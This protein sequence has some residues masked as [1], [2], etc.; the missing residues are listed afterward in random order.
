MH[1]FS[2]ITKQMPRVSTRTPEEQKE[3]RRQYMNNYRKEW[4]KSHNPHIVCPDCGATVRRFSVRYHV[5]TVKHLYHVNPVVRG[6][7]EEIDRE[8]GHIPIKIHK[9]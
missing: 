5:K 7:M 3:Q 6:A 9:H 4:A 8:I 1:L 2:C